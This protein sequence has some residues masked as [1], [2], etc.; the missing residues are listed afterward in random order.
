MTSHPRCQYFHFTVAKQASLA[1]VVELNRGHF[2]AG[3]HRFALSEEEPSGQFV[4]IENSSVITSAYLDR[5]VGETFD[6]NRR[7][8]CFVNSSIVTNIH[9]DRNKAGTFGSKWKC[10]CLV[11]SFVVTSVYLDK[12]SLRLLAVAGSA[13][14]S[15]T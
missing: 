14:A 4:L 12:I 10:L 1:R 8:L 11:N 2:L 9:L 7:R 6:G 5:N 15:P 13:F 3:K